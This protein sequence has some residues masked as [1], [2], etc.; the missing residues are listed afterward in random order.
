MELFTSGHLCLQPR[1]FFVKFIFKDVIMD[2]TTW[3]VIINNI[4]GLF[5]KIKK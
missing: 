1:S 3:S 5:I 2:S 4:L